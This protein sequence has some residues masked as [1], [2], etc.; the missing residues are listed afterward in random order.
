MLNKLFKRQQKYVT[1]L[2]C[3]PQEKFNS[4]VTESGFAKRE[5]DNGFVCAS[6]YPELMDYL[7]K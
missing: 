3:L 4:V 7:L 6:R 1:D 5:L 2:I